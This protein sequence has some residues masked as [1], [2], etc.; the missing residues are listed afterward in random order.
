[1]IVV[2]PRDKRTREICQLY[3]AAGLVLAF[4]D[5]SCG[6]SITWL[7]VVGTGICIH[8]LEVTAKLEY[9][10]C[11]ASMLASSLFM[12]QALVGD[13]SICFRRPS[14]KHVHLCSSNHC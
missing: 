3:V 8:G 2:L 13:K 11:L 9:N 14:A 6:C 12:V 7:I 1:M 10:Q 4:I 5:V